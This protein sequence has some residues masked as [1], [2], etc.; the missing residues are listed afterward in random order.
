MSKIKVTLAAVAI[1]VGLAGCG[2]AGG[3]QR[4]HP[5]QPAASSTA[6]TGNQA[7]ARRLDGLYGAQLGRGTLSKSLT[8]IEPALH[9]HGGWWTLTID[10]GANRLNI[11][12]PQEGNFEQR[13]TAVDGSHI[14]LA[15]DTGC[16]QRGAARTQPALLAWF[17]SGVHLR[18]KAVSVPCLTDKVLLTLSAWRKT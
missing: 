6:A 15:P 8:T 4:E 2:G 11:S 16:E 1:A 14:E 5:A 17:R 3:E 9:L 13:I 12:H 10:V 7:I 18:L